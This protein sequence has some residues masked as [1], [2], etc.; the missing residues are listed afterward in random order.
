MPPEG[1]INKDFLKQ[2][3]RDKKQLLKKCEVQAIQVPH[4]DELSVKAL[5][6]QFKKD[7]EMMAY[8]P[9]HYPVGKAPPREYFFNVLNTV[10]PEYLG[11]VLIHANKQRNSVEGEKM[12]EEAIQ[13]SQFWE[14]QLKQMPYMSSK[15]PHFLLPS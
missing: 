6:P 3:L 1:V 2:V 5:Y 15:C 14:E 12:K 7:A 9:D 4:Y 13:I 10:H 8:F 11:Q